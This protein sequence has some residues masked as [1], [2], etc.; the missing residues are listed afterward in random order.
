MSKTINEYVTKRS[1]SGK[2]Y[3]VFYKGTA[4]PEGTYYI[5]AYEYWKNG[6][7]VYVEPHCAMNR[8]RR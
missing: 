1:E 5:G 6:K 3:R 7:K 8:R 4:C 2:E